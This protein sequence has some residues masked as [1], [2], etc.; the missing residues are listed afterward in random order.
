MRLDGSQR[1]VISASAFYTVGAYSWDPSGE[2]LVYQ[3]LE[4][5]SSGSLPQV[6]VWR[7]AGT[8]P[9]LLAEDA[10]FPRWLP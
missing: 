1:E 2:M 10:V 8:E 4:F 7:G 6:F 9:E 5:G 3:S